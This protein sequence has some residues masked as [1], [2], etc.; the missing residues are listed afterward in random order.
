MDWEAQRRHSGEQGVG[1]SSWG[2]PDGDPSINFGA[3]SRV[4][5]CVEIDASA[6]E[7]W[8]TG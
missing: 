6:T 7:R 1:W 8:L 3:L 2:S 4:N 5:R